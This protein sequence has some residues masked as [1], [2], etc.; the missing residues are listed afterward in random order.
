M[1]LTLTLPFII[2]GSY[3]EILLSVSVITL[4]AAFTPDLSDV[5]CQSKFLLAQMEP[6]GDVTPGSPC[7]LLF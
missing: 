3:E 5:Y 7:F 4:K 6:S 1:N 2:R